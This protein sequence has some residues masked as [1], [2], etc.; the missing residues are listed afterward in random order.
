MR[1]YVVLLD[2]SHIHPILSDTIQT[3]YQL[4]NVTFL[5]CRRESRRGIPESPF[6]SNPAFIIPL[7][8]KSVYF[9][10]SFTFQ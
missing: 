1:Y 4:V 6:S 5:H 3:V 9:H 2:I 7:L 10:T 8:L